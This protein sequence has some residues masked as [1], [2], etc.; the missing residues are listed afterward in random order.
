[1]KPARTKKDDLVAI[2]S[3]HIGKARGIPAK[4]LA[5]RLG[6]RERHL[7]KVITDAI[8][9]GIAIVGDPTTGYYVAE[10]AE[11]VQAS[12]AFHRT[13]ARHELKKASLLRRLAL[14]DLAGQLKL[15]T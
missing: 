1:M 4:D 14:P 10:T 6:V 2:M 9:E 12:I 5:L 7:R 11:D 15:R 13:R 8:A 3:C